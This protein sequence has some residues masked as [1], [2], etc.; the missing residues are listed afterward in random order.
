MTHHIGLFSQIVNAMWQFWRG[1]IHRRPGKEIRKA[2][3]AQRGWIEETKT[4]TTTITQET[5][6]FLHE[7]SEGD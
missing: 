4:T 6:R 2:R 1:I 3:K 7:Y 5:K